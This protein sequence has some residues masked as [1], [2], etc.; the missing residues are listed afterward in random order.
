MCGALVL[1]FLQYNIYKTFKEK[2]NFVFKSKVKSHFLKQ[3][4]ENSLLDIQPTKKSIG[5]FIANEYNIQFSELTFFQSIEYIQS[6]LPELDECHVFYNEF[7]VKQKLFQI[8]KN[9]SNE[10]EESLVF[11][12][13]CDVASYG[14]NLEY[15]RILNL[16]GDILTENELIHEFVKYP[17]TKFI[18]GFQTRNFFLPSLCVQLKNKNKEI[19]P[20]KREYVQEI[21]EW[22]IKPFDVN[23]KENKFKKLQ[24][25]FYEISDILEKK[26]DYDIIEKN[27]HSNQFIWCLHG[28]NL[29]R[30]FVMYLDIL[31][32][33]CSIDSFSAYLND[34][35]IKQSFGR[36]F[37]PTL[38]LDLF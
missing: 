35:N 15:E 38:F 7:N 6:S 30:L 18:C 32:K 3:E 8:L 10:A 26:I 28:E 14:H 36:L 1:F 13:I 4:I 31:G 33:D 29:T 22:I 17:K 11:L 16:Q 37:P 24:I 34:Q 23:Y 20:D 12:W 19:K 21:K 5:I 9:N 27:L 25:E 2:Q